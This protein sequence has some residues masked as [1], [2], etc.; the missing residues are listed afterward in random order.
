MA[1]GVV[2]I[3]IIFCFTVHY[4]LRFMILFLFTYDYISIFM[5]KL[6]GELTSLLFLLFCLMFL[7]IVVGCVLYYYY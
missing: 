7:F 4:C 5:K 3:I 6:N 1:V 2:I